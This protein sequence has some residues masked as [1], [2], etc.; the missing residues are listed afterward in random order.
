M[1]TGIHYNIENAAYHADRTAIGA[2]GLKA[3]RRGPAYFYGQYLD[4]LCPVKEEKSDDAARLFGNMTHCALFEP[5]RFAQ[6]YPVGTLDP[7]LKSPKNGKAWQA[8][9]AL[10]A[11]RGATLVDASQY[12]AAAHVVKSCMA[13]PGIAKWFEPGK[14]FGEVTICV[15]DPVHMGVRRKIRVDLL[16]VVSTHP[17]GSPD[18]VVLLDGKSYASV[19]A[20]E[21]KRQVWRMGYDLQSAFYV[22]TATLA[23][24]TVLGFLFLA[25]ENEY[26]HQPK[27]FEIGAVP[28][29]NGRRKYTAALAQYAECRSSGYWPGPSDSI[30]TI[31]DVPPWAME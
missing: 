17:D 21:F 5:D 26:P 2:S 14:W 12:E 9:K 22:D 3:M 31:D 23:G 30:E 16:H 6:R 27:L 20:E 4:P 24:M 10:H 8:E 19:Q 25:F 29:L 13:V 18:K 15:N 28:F 7:A 11:E 1:D